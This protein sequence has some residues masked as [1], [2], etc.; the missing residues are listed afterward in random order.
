[1]ADLR[2]V[3]EIVWGTTLDP[4]NF[5]RKATSSEGFLQPLDRATARG[6]GRPAKLYRAGPAA[7]L[8]PPLMRPR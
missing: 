7:W 2:R 4:R 8:T 6:A 1:M 3:Y 5:H